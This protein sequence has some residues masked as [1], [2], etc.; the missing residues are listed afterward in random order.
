M[1]SVSNKKVGNAI[2]SLGIEEFVLYGEPKNEQE[3]NSMFR[4][5]VGKDSSDSAILS[6]DPSD[7]GVTWSQVKP[8]I[9]ELEAAEPMRLLRLERNRRLAETDWM[10]NSDVVMADDWKTYRQALRDLPATAEP[11]LENEQLINVTWPEVPE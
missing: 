1:T 10:A 2:R 7:F 9:A 4:K 11:K 5:V 6:S 8:K 3:F